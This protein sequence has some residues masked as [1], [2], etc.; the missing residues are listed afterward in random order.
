VHS[1][2]EAYLDSV[3]DYKVTG[4]SVAESEYTHT[5]LVACARVGKAVVMVAVFLGN[6]LARAV[7]FGV[8]DHVAEG[9]AKSA[10]G[11]FGGIVLHILFVAC[12]ATV[13]FEVEIHIVSVVVIALDLF[14]KSRAHC[15]GQSRN[16]KSQEGKEC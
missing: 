9:V 7:G 8:S 16:E 3:A 10:V 5:R 13:V 1:E 12:G 4:S 6:Q 14:V 15:Q 11:V 2:A